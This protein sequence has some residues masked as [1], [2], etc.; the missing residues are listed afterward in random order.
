MISANEVTANEKLPKAYDDAY[1]LLVF[2]V[3]KKTAVGIHLN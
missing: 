3:T 1:V 2:S